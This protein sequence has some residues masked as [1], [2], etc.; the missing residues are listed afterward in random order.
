MFER[1]SDQITRCPGRGLCAAAVDVVGAVVAV[2]AMAAFASG[3]TKKKRKKV[4]HP[5][6]AGPAI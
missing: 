2:A 3:D 5:A 1:L 6:A 4:T